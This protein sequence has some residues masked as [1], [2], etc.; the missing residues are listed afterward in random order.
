MKTVRV[1]IFGPS[2]CTCCTA[3]C[4]RQNGHD[5]AALLRGDETRKFAAFGVEVAI[6]GD[7]GRV[8][9][10]GVLPYV[11]GRCQFLGENDLCTIYDDRPAACRAFECVAD[12]N[13]D[14]VGAHG[15]F[16]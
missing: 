16:L 10:E 3:A 9:V 6:R 7:D 1:A 12:F 15:E 4:C 5:Y 14:G 11:N 2:P 13:R 8:L